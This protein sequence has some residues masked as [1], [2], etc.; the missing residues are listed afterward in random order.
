ML[1]LARTIALIAVAIVAVV[2]LIQNL[3]T[4]EVAFLTWSIA[5]PRA[6]VFALLFAAGLLAGY[7]LNALRRKAPRSKAATSAN[8]DERVAPQNE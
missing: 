1:G 4:I 2:F 8:A 5:A 6:I 7:L 3:A